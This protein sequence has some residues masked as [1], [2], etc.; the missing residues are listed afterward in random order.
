[1]EYVSKLRFEKFGNFADSVGRG[2]VEKLIGVDECA[3]LLY[4]INC[5]I[6]AFVGNKF[7]YGVVA[8]TVEIIFVSIEITGICLKVA[9]VVFFGIVIEAR[10]AKSTEVPAAVGAWAEI[11]A[12]CRLCSLTIPD[13]LKWQNVDIVYPSTV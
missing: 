8:D 5:F 2:I 11:Y 6:E 12:A 10:T 7:L 3:R 4:F 1:M 9:V 13:A